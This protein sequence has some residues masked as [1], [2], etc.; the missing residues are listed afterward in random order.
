MPLLW[1]RGTSILPPHD[2]LYP[3]TM[4]SEY[5]SFVG[6]SWGADMAAGLYAAMASGRVISDPGVA[7]LGSGSV[8]RLGIAHVRSPSP[9]STKKMARVPPLFYGFR[10]CAP[11]LSR[12]ALPPF[13]HGTKKWRE[14]HPC[15]PGVLGEATMM[16]PPAM[17]EATFRPKPRRSARPPAMWE[18]TSSAEAAP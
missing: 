6:P 5:F 7:P 8:R 13:S 15:F 1:R 4:A 9:F 2:S 10:R 16:H 12:R 18:A 14:C 3:A 17:W 11:A